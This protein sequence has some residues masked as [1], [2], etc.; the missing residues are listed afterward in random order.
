MK[1]R[2][3]SSMMQRLKN[4]LETF[5]NSGSVFV[6]KSLLLL[7]CLEA[8]AATRDTVKLTVCVCVCVCLCIPA[9]AMRRKLTV[10]IGF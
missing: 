4:I 3:H 10:S 9:V 1:C 7:L 5:Q 8:L 6:F 2:F